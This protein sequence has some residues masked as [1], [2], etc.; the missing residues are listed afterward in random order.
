MKMQSLLFCSIALVSSS[1]LTAAAADS[2][3]KAGAA[4]ATPASASAPMTEGEVKKV[5]KDA[6]KIT[7]QH[8]PIANLEMPGMTMAFRVKDPAM[9]NAVKAGDK[10]RFA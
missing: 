6:G 1:A 8:G 5:D 2:P 9:L 4:Q 10:I 3:A 7:I